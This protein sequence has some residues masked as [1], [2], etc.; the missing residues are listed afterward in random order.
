M[1]KQFLNITPRQQYTSWIHE[2]TSFSRQLRRKVKPE[3]TSVKQ[4][5]ND[6]D[7]L[8]MLDLV[9]QLLVQQIHKYHHITFNGN[10]FDERLHA[11]FTKWRL[12]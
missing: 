3:V 6:P 4:T 7:C 9:D 2:Y 5:F 1:E 10:M 11:L 8:F 12:I